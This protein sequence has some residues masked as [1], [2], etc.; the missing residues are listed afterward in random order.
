[1]AA[2]G[3]CDVSPC[4]GVVVGH[5]VIFAEDELVYAGPLESRPDADGKL[6]FVNTADFARLKAAVEKKRH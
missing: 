1:M 6:V 4:D 5:C 3:T 2:P